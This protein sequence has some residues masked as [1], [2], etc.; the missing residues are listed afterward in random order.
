MRLCATGLEQRFGERPLFSA[1]DC[2]VGPGESLAL[3]GPSGAGKS[4]LLRLLAG[5]DTPTAGSISWDGQAIERLSPRRRRD[6]RQRH[7]GLLEQDPDLDE[8]LDAR[9]NILLPTAFR[10]IAEASARCDELLAAMQLTGQARQPAAVLSGGQQVRV[11]VARTLLP[12]P[13]LVLADE[14]TASLDPATAIAVSELLFARQAAEGFGLVLATHDVGLA[15]RCDRR[16]E[17]GPC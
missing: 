9:E 14:P 4:S 2:A 10:P 13:A 6:L 12:R 15:E 8:R 16:L 1:L 7:L 11:A 5:L 3:T 17:L